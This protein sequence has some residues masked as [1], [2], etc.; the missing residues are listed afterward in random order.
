MSTTSL[1]YHAFGMVGYRHVRSEYTGG[2]VRFRLEDN[3]VFRCTRCGSSDVIKRGTNLRRFRAVPIGRKPVFIEVPV[4]RVGCSVCGNVR[5][6]ETGFADK[7]R[8]YTRAFE[9]F[10]LDLS[11]SMTI[12]DVARHLGVSWDTVKDIQKRN[13]ERRYAHISLKDVRLIAIDEISI[14][15]GHRYMTIVLDLKTGAIV[16][17]GDGRGSKS[18]DPFWRKLKHSK[19]R[20][21]AVAMDMSPAYALAVH[22]HLPESVIVFDHFHIIKMFNEQL[23]ELRRALQNQVE[24][25][26]HKRIIKGS[27]WLLLKAL[28]NL[29]SRHKEKLEEALSLN[30]PLAMAYYLKEDLRQLW[31]QQDKQT[32]ALFLDDWIARARVSG[33][34]MLHE[35][36]KMLALH[37]FG[38]LAW[39][40]FPISTGPLEGTNNKIRTLQKRAYG[41][42]DND[43]FKLKLY[44]LHESKYALV[45]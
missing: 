15:K 21:E 10:V 12:Y 4:Q 41:F 9:R 1:L 36:A 35:F 23:S 18:L 5:Q 39:Y 16:F 30:Q 42:R 17:V 2:S 40:D 14:G 27:R 34:R 32:A 13:L 38:I 19:A 31:Y 7:R 25:T 6:V 3:R 29:S 44:A 33:I 24:S 37:R 28:E 11:K 8:T 43:F 22:K 26:M 45:G 20:I